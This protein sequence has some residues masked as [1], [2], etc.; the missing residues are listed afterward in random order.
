M[1][2]KLSAG[3]IAFSVLLGRSAAAQE[4]PYFVTYTHH[5]EEPG[6]LEVSFTP[7]FGVPK[8]GPRFLAP[9]I[10][11]YGGMGEWRNV[12][13]ADTSH[14][15]APSLAWSLPN[16]VTFRVSPTIGLTANSH[17]A[18]MRFGMSYEIPGLGHR[19]GHRFH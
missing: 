8:E 1:T 14:Y 17:R 13:F 12:T 3:L 9:W 2:R 19:V 6:A 16:G 15:L 11:L 10:E 5:M 4:S 18:L 7:V